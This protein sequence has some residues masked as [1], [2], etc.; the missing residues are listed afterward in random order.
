MKKS[1]DFDKILASNNWLILLKEVEEKYLIS[2]KNAGI[3]QREDNKSITKVTRFLLVYK[4][5]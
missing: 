5:K 1:I 4:H 2:Q 3:C